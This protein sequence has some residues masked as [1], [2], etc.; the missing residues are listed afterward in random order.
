MVTVRVPATTANLGPGFDTM[1]LALNL[2][3]YIELTEVA[4]GLCIDVEGEG[5]DVIPKTTS[6]I[7]YR[8]VM[9]VFEK[10]G[11]HPRGLKI[12]LRNFIP[13][14]RGMGSSAAALVGGVYAANALA[15][16]PLSGDEMLQIAASFEGHPDNVAPALF[17]GIVISVMAQ[18]QV[19][20]RR[21]TPPA[22]LSAIVAI[23]DFPLATK[24]A[25]QVLPDNVPIKD[26]V[27]NI[28]HSALLVLAFVKNDYE[29]LGQ[30]MQDRIHQ[31]YR[32][33]LIP[34]MEEVFD[35]AIAAGA[36]GVALSGAGPTLIAFTRGSQEAVGKAMQQA[37]NKHNISC[38][39][40]TLRPVRKGAEIVAEEME[41]G[42]N[43]YCCTEVWG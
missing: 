5:S 24:I 16:N 42:Q 27:F 7:V 20:F 19:I 15:G 21:I 43:G 17:G 6:N 25:R 12:K 32:L 9:A 40:K 8:A 36:L 18:E 26:A 3:N 2:Y 22:E 33:D 30:A 14:A 10:C 34:G 38:S 4:S 13:V 29:L 28:G 39:I 23:P 11:Y 31:P 35:A 37:F 1:G 41:D